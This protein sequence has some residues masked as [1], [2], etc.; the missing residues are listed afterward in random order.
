MHPL[1]LILVDKYGRDGRNSVLTDCF[2]SWDNLEVNRGESCGE[3]RT[4]GEPVEQRRIVNVLQ[5]PAFSSKTAICDSAIQRSSYRF[6]VRPATHQ[7]APFLN[8]A[9]YLTSQQFGVPSRNTPRLGTSLSTINSSRP[10]GIS[11]GLLQ[12]QAKH[13]S[14][15]AR[16]AAR[17]RPRSRRCRLL[18]VAWV[19]I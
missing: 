18:P 8:P 4:I 19:L 16:F 1:C 17:N 5:C 11:R 9:L 2:L 13:S 12:A 6:S 15:G 14:S 7:R 3:F 10:H